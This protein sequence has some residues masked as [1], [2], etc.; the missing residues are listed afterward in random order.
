MDL[1]W[2]KDFLTLAEQKTFSRAADVRNVTQPAFSRRIRALEDWTGTPLFVRGA[3]GTTLTT[4]HA[5]PAG[6]TFGFPGPGGA[7]TEGYETELTVAVVGL[8]A[9]TRVGIGIAVGLAL[10]L[11]L[12]RLIGRWIDTGTRDPFMIL[13]VSLVLIAVAALACIIPARRATGIDPMT[14]LRCE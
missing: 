1:D 13:T 6:W 8:S 10:R 3:Q 9:G 12:N 4:L 7:A 5:N 2:L 14:A 11:D